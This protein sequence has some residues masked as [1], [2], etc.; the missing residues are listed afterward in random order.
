MNFSNCLFHHLQATGVM[1]GKFV[2]ARVYSE[3]GPLVSDRTGVAAGDLNHI[4][5]LQAI[6]SSVGNAWSDYVRTT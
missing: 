1:P 5:G 6:F 3:A 2:I 4:A